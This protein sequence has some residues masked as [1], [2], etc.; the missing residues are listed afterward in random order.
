MFILLLL[1]T[2]IQGGPLWTTESQK[3]LCAEIAEKIGFDFTKYVAIE[4]LVEDV[5]SDCPYCCMLLFALPQ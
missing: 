4:L 5:A 2:L 3:A 1:L